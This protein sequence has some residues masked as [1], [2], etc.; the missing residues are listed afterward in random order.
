MVLCAS[1]FPKSSQSIS[2]QADLVDRTAGKGL[3]FIW[4]GFH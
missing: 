3:L 1:R 4:N 2:W